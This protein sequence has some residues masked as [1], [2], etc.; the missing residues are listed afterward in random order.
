M[1]LGFWDKFAQ[2]IITRLDEDCKGK[3]PKKSAEGT[4]I[5]EIN[6]ISRNQLPA[7]SDEDWD[8]ENHRARA[9]KRSSEM[10]NE[11]EKM[12]QTN[13]SLK[14]GNSD[15][16]PTQGNKSVKLRPHQEEGLNHWKDNNFRG[17]LRHATGS[18]KTITALTAIKEHSA[19]GLPV[20]ILVPSRL[21]LEQW[22]YEVES[23]IPNANILPV[24]SGYS[25][26]KKLLGVWT[27]EETSRKGVGLLLRLTI[28][29]GQKASQCE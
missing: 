26:W 14:N 10:Y 27:L 16:N 12:L 18:G 9:A 20:V 8:P 19:N 17:I 28:R 29:Q 25:D 3:F 6:S 23:F 22:K 4:I 11:F 21:L 1:P 2:P 7:I 24:G 15:K 5:V 13:A